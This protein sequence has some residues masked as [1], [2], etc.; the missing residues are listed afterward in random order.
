MVLIADIDMQSCLDLHLQRKKFFREFR[1]W[2]PMVTQTGFFKIEIPIIQLRQTNL[3][4]RKHIMQW[5]K[6][7]NLQQSQPLANRINSKFNSLNIRV[8]QLKHKPFPAASKIRLIEVQSPCLKDHLGVFRV[9]RSLIRSCNQSVYLN[10]WI[11]WSL[12]CHL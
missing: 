7:W 5:I 10:R 3:K 12:P 6:Q 1:I 4:F 8:P 11:I 2:H 9:S